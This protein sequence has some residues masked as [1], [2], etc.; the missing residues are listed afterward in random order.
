LNNRNVHVGADVKTSAVAYVQSIDQ[1]SSPGTK[2]VVRGVTTDIDS[3]RHVRMDETYANVPVWGADIVVHANQTTFGMVQGTALTD[4]EGFDVAATIAGPQ[5]LARAEQGYAATASAPLAALAFSREASE[6]VI[7]PQTAADPRLAWHVTFFTE[8][9]AGMTPGSWHYFIDAATGESIESFNALDTLAEASGPGGNA[10]FAHAWTSNLDVEPT[11]TDGQYQMA[12]SRVVTLDLNNGTSGGTVVVGPLDNISDAVIDDAHGYAQVT[13][14]MLRDWQGYN[15]IDNNGFVISS[16][17]HYDTNYENAFWDG[18]EMTYGDGGTTFYPLSGAVDVVGHEIDHGFTSF[19]SNL[20]YTGMSGGLN[21]A[22]SDIAGKT[23][24]FYFKGADATWDIGRDIFRADAALRFMCDP[25]QDGY[26]I[27]NAAAYTDFLDVHYTSGVMNKAFCRTAKRLAGSDPD[28]G[29]ATP[30]SVL[31]ASKAWYLANASYWT[32]ST[33]FVQACEGVLDAASALNYTTDEREAIRQSWADVGVACG[34]TPT[35][36]LSPPNPVVAPYGAVE[37]TITLDPAVDVDT[38]IGLTA[39]PTTAGTLPSVVT[40]PAHATSA[41]FS[42][43]DLGTVTTATIYATSAA[44]TAQVTVSTTGHLVINE[45]DYDQIGTDSGEFVEIYN[46]T[47]APISL[48][49]K[50]LIFVNGKNNLVYRTVD[51]APAGT[52]P[53]HGYLVVAGPNVV[54]PTPAIKLDPGWTTN[55]IQNGSPD[56]IALIDTVAPSLEDALSYEGLV[57]AASLPGFGTATSLVEGT[58]LPATVA[59]SSSVTGSLCR[60]PDGQDTNDAATDWAFFATPTP[61]LPDQ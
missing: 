7:L 16:R 28:A 8:L 25:T 56:G 19:H 2:W 5:A 15:S 29:S 37:L 41:T 4:L 54:V 23:T 34:V 12:T 26:S 39:N 44:S 53:S 18:S 55:M 45:V 11:A 32:S 50:H 21:E 14:D 48:A 24:E 13:L 35:L 9:Q 51:L 61:G 57:T 43:T 58:P 42:Y 38:E 46:P 27:D 52:L 3:Q 47:S 10:K 49:T 31:R 22:F 33:T 60:R 6:L 20:T 40:I 59:D 1:L 36:S 30:D 17:V